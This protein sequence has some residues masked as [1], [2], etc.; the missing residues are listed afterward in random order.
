MTHI[1]I[2]LVFLFA[3]IST[4]VQAQAAPNWS[5]TPPA[6]ASFKP[7]A[8]PAP[9]NASV[10][11]TGTYTQTV[12]VPYPSTWPFPANAPSY[13]QSLSGSG[14]VGALRMAARFALPIMLAI[15]GTKWLMDC[16]GG[17]IGDCPLRPAGSTKQAD[18][19]WTQPAPVGSEQTL[20]CLSTYPSTS[21]G[22]NIFY[23]N[24]GTRQGCF[25]DLPGG[26]SY[27]VYYPYPGG[28]PA[29][30][31]A[32]SAGICVFNPLSPTA[33]AA[34]SAD[35][36][37]NLAANNGQKGL[38]AIRAIT[39]G[40]ASSS[41]PVAVSNSIDAAV[42]AIPQGR[43]ISL[44]NS[45]PVPIPEPYFYA[46][47]P[48]SH[49]APGTY[50]SASGGCWPLE[51][52][53]QVSTQP[54]VQPSTQPGVAPTIQFVPVPAND[55]NFI[56]NPPPGYSYDPDRN[57]Y[58]PTNVEPVPATDPNAPPV[59][60]PVID[61]ATGFDMAPLLQP[62]PAPADP[63]APTTDEIKNALNTSNFPILDAL[64]GWRL[65]AHTSQCALGSFNFSFAPANF[66]QDFSLQPICDRFEEYRPNISAFFLFMWSI[67]P[68]FV[69]LRS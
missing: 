59:I 24:D 68:L 50:L 13:T 61:P 12:R 42:D 62:S 3:V 22:A 60:D 5:L 19:T 31:S 36:A 2:I 10:Y 14:L 32:N 39:D 47:P 9:A 49:C 66:S 4:G 37:K 56:P 33:Q 51:A 44:S 8:F 6:P 18:G 57:V 11:G 63:Q 53:V 69:V 16:D 64:K 67:L 1:K 43:T 29:G 40:I 55:P 34:A 27:D 45:A 23:G 7:S 35:F 21:C 38:D 15:E 28:C 17:G 48:E 26:G 58:Y 54:Q 25:C 52:P 30:A 65:P 20:I 46:P 41:D